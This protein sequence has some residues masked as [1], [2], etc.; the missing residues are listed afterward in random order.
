MVLCIEF[1]FQS[2]EAEIKE[3]ATWHMTD[4]DKVLGSQDADNEG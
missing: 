2:M 3:H 1:Q 4:P